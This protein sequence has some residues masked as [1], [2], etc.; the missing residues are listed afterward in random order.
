MRINTVVFGAVLG[1][2]AGTASLLA[3]NSFA[4]EYDANKLVKVTGI[5]TK[6]EWMNSH[7]RFYVAV[8]DADGKVTTWNFELGAI[9]VLLKQGWRKNSLKEGDQVTVEGLRAKDNS[10]AASTR[11]VLWPDGRRVFGGSAVEDG[12]PPNQ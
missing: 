8:K 9:P 4:A 5:V 11:R 3:H 6:V 10:Y 2:M 12:A 1:L 7:A